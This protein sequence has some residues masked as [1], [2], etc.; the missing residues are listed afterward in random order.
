[1][2]QLQVI[3]NK[4]RPDKLLLAISGNSQHGSYDLMASMKEVI[5]KISVASP[6]QYIEAL[7]QD[8]NLTSETG[9]SPESRTPEEMETVLNAEKCLACIVALTEQS[10]NS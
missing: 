9:I 7:L 4:H 6:S 1:M 5:E 2:R 3:V 10:Q 8:A